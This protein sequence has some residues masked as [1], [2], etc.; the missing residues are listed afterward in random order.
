MVVTARITARK[1][2]QDVLA[3]GQVELD[4]MITIKGIKLVGNKKN[5][6]YRVILPFS[7]GRKSPCINIKDIDLLNKITDALAAQ[8]SSNFR[9]KTGK[10]LRER[11]LNF[12]KQHRPSV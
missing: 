10:Y 2:T 7:E 6:R 5:D 4:N 8:Y 11:S 3:I 12:Y 9:T 1:P